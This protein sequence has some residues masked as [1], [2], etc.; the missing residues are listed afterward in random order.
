MR[1][2]YLFKILQELETTIT[3]RQ[4]NF[5]CDMNLY[6][7]KENLTIKCFEIHFYRKIV[8]VD[9]PNKK[10]RFPLSL[11]AGTNYKFISRSSTSR[12]SPWKFLLLEHYVNLNLNRN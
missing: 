7:K 8:D 6:N 11:I 2:L 3:G 1:N 5:F 12:N 4:K 9:E 10:K